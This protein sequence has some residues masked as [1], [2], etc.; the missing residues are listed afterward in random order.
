MIVHVELFTDP[1]CPWASSA[2]PQ[3]RRLRWLHGEQLSRTPRMVV[4][5]ARGEDQESPT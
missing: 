3:R 2:E 1:L 5:A 4:L